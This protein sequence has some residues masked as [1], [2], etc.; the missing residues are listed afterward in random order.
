[1]KRLIFTAALLFAFASAAVFAQPRMTNTPHGGMLVKTTNG[2]MLEMVV[3]YKQ[4]SFYLFDSKENPLAMSVQMGKTMNA[5]VRDA[6]VK[7]QFSD[8]TNAD[9]P[10]RVDP[11]EATAWIDAGK[12]QKF[13]ATV[14]FTYKGKADTA[15]FD[16]DAMTCC[17][18]MDES[19]MKEMKK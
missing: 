16:F 6:N 14:S 17:H 11:A 10:L 15:V 8:G 12:S 4:V 18:K 19:G 7:I 1:M 13:K 9:A 3:R 2:N 5:Q